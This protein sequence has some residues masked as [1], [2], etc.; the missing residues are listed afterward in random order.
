MLGWNKMPADFSESPIRSA[1][2]ILVCSSTLHIYA[3]LYSCGTKVSFLYSISI[4]GQCFLTKFTATAKQSSWSTHTELECGKIEWEPAFKLSCLPCSFL[5]RSWFWIPQWLVVISWDNLQLW[6]WTCRFDPIMS[7][8]SR[9]QYPALRRLLPP[10]LFSQ[11][12]G[13]L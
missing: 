9:C 1:P 6:P 10:R 3:I 11:A 5:V 13:P 7:C 12:P 2:H 4:G 8:Y